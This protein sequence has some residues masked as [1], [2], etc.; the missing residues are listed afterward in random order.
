[1][2]CDLVFKLTGQLR[3]N[4]KDTEFPPIIIQ[5]SRLLSDEKLKGLPE[6]SKFLLGVT[7][8]N[9]ARELMGDEAKKVQLIETLKQIQNNSARRVTANDLKR[10][11][12]VGNNKFS[13]LRYKYAGN[14][15]VG[16]F[17][18]LT[19][20]YDPDILL[21]KKLSINGKNLKDSIYGTDT[22]GNKVFI[23]EDS[24]RGVSKLYRHLKLRDLILNKFEDSEELG[25]M[26]KQLPPDKK[27]DSQKELLLDF[28][29]NRSEY[30]DIVWK[31]GLFG[32]LHEITKNLLN[33]NRTGFTDPLD[34]E[35]NS[36]VNYRANSSV[37]SIPIKS[38]LD[39]V[40]KFN[41]ELLEGKKRRDLSSEEISEIYEQFKDNFEDFTGTLVQV[42]DKD[43]KIRSK[44]FK[45]LSETDDFT[46]D[47]VKDF[48]TEEDLYR[49]FHIYKYDDGEKT[50]Y[51][52]SQ[53]ILTP[54]SRARGYERIEDIYPRINEYYDKSY[55][56]STGFRSAFYIMDQ[57]ER[58]NSIND[59]RYYAP[60]SVVQ[61][62]DVSLDRDTALNQDE[63]LIITGE[64]K[65]SD[66]YKHFKKQLTNE[67]YTE[68]TEVVDSIETA[69]IFTYLINDAETGVGNAISLRD[70]R[71]NSDHQK[72]LQNI[73]N[74]IT[75]AKKKE[76]KKYFIQ[77]S[78]GGFTR[79]IPISDSVIMDE[80][81]HRPQPIL[82][83]LDEVAEVLSRYGVPVEV[84]TQDQL[85]ER[86]SNIPPGTR[87]FINEGKIYVNGSIGTSED[88]IHEYTHLFL[89]LLKAQNYDGYMKLLD[90]VTSS[91]DSRINHYRR[92]VNKKY[93]SLSQQDKD[94]EIFVAAFA[95]FLSGKRSSDLFA[96]VK[97]EV[98]KVSKSIF[99]KASNEDFNKLY[100]GRVDDIFSTFSRD[101]G[102]LGN[103]LDFS[104]GAIYRQAAN[105]ISDQIKDGNIIEDCLP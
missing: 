26:M 13:I 11:G 3:G 63:E 52:Y 73:F 70:F 16:E 14:E 29:E 47:T 77:E 90:R 62:L 86:F 7:L 99:N 31:R 97:E 103:G 21:V 23:V 17:P 64:K 69:G 56:F 102:K 68:L 89:G 93:K 42:T 41:P 104:Q 81:Y 60:G 4:S 54:E 38:F 66:F 57:Y 87:A 15:E 5:N 36:R 100:R 12:I 85:D 80:T 76:Y 98:D 65:L 37:G 48:V 61:V 46:Y 40:E 30:T 84:L 45:N 25:K 10:K 2:G 9:I 72:K 39:I 20:P 19:T 95:D 32:L 96:E 58:V 28:I 94:E 74:T 105:W 18:E 51:Y 101:I 82:G 79:I 27:F 88:L 50:K 33:E 59:G 1:M 75:E 71:N 35:F 34:R 24:V 6:Q 49:G 53:D 8:K 22:N 44:F 43:L 67:Q 92:E 83:L 78:R 55:Y 91:N